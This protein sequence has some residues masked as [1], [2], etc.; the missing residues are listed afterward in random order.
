MADM[1]LIL[2][3]KNVVKPGMMK[4]SAVDELAAVKIYRGKSGGSYFT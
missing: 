3:S 1:S 2:P 4:G